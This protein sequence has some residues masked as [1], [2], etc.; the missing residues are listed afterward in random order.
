MKWIEE[1]RSGNKEEKSQIIREQRTKKKHKLDHLK[2]ISL[3][4]KKWENK[5]KLN[6]YKKN[7]IGIKENNNTAEKK[8]KSL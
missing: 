3:N 6:K 4:F 7:N 8:G 1:I 2:I 5:K